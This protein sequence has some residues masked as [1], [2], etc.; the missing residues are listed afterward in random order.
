MRICIKL[1][2]ILERLLVHW[3]QGPCRF[4]IIDRRITEVQENFERD[5]GYFSRL[6]DAPFF[7]F[8]DMGIKNIF[9][10]TFRSAW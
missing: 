10:N 8:G 2:I 4:F 7:I 1:G 3:E 5:G 6:R 9:G